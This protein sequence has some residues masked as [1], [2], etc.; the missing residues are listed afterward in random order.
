MPCVDSAALR[1]DVLGRAMPAVRST[2]QPTLSGWAI[3]RPRVCPRDRLRGL[4]R[5]S[6]NCDAYGSV[7]AGGW[8]VDAQRLED[9][10]SSAGPTRPRAPATLEER[11]RRRVVASRLFFGG[12]GALAIS[13][14]LPWVSVLTI[15]QVHLTGG[16]IVLVLGVAGLYAGAGYLVGQGRVTRA[17]VN[18]VWVLNA[19]MAILIILIFDG[20]GGLGNEIVSPGAGV[21]VAGIGVVVSVAATIQLH[22]SGAGLP[23]VTAAVVAWVQRK[24]GH[25]AVVD[26]PPWRDDV[27]PPPGA[28]ISPD[29]LYWWDDRAG[30][31]RLINEEDRHPP[32]ARRCS[33]GHAVNDGDLFC[34]E[35]GDP[36]TQAQPAN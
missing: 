36:V 35:C 16:D 28:E 23:R 18:G 12:G 29:G 26:E 13:S 11:E 10:V 25:A 21:F 1:G 27:S 17:L 6:P 8:A 4:A 5:R 32:P 7:A 9:D 3:A 14:F 24:L 15:A 30:R 33:K 34:G 31:W 19:L 2:G 20:L 22:R